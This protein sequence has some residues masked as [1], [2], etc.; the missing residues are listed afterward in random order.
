ME[1]RKLSKK[2][3]RERFSQFAKWQ[4]RLE[5]INE[6]KPIRVLSDTGSFVVEP[7]NPLYEVVGEF[8]C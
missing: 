7:I 2:E 4:R 5:Q 3:I 8:P 1:D 6:Q